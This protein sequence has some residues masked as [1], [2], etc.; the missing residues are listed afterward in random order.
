MTFF[1]IFSKT[2]GDID[3]KKLVKIEMLN[4]IVGFYNNTLV[5]C[6]FCLQLRLLKSY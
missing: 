3:L 1:M 4:S 5:S 6:K 2:F